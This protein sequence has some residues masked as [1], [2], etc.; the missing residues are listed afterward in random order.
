M[1]FKIKKKVNTLYDNPE[2]LFRDRRNRTVQGPLSHQ[3]DIL[4]RY[5][6]EAFE[7][8]NV[9]LELPTGSGKTLVGLLIA[10]FRRITKNERVLYLCPTRQL[11]LQVCEQSERKYGIIATPFIGPKKDYD[12]KDKISYQTG[13]TI[14]VAPYSSLFNTNPFFDKPQLIILDDAHAAENYIAS[15][16]SLKI[17]RFRFEKIYLGL[18]AIIKE[19]LPFSEYQRF[20]SDERDD[21]A[22][23]YIEKIPTIKLVSV[24]HEIDAFLDE[25]T[26]R[27]D[28][29]FSWSFLKGHL[30]ACHLYMSYDQI[31]IRPYIP[32][33]L[34]HEPFAYATQR[35]FMSA[36]LGNGGD[37]ERI[38]GVPSLH[39][40]PIPTGWDKQG[41]GRRY[42]VFP[43]IS[44]S[45]DEIEPLTKDIV[46][47]AGRALILVPNDRRVEK[48]KKLFEDITIYTA[49]DIE[50]SKD[51]FISSKESAVAVLAN[52]YDGIDLLDEDCR[53]L[54]IEGLPKA[55]NLQELYLMSRMVA[56]NLFKDRIRTRMIQAFGRCTRSATDYATVVIIGED[57]YD[58]LVLEENRSLFHPE[59][60]GELIFGADQAEEM[61]HEGFLENINIFLEHSND[62]D[63]IDAD[64]RENR[65]KASQSPLPGEARLLEAAQLE[66]KYIYK[67]WQDNYEECVDLSQKISDILVGD[68][69][70]GLRGLWYYF[71]ASASEL[72][73]QQLGDRAFI[74]KASDLYKRTSACLPAISWLR[75]LA[76]GAKS[77]D[78]E[79][80]LKDDILLE[81]NIERI[82]ALFEQRSF[83][84]PRKFE[85]TAKGIIKGLE[86]DDSDEFEEAHRLLGEMLGFESINPNGNATPDPLW[87]SNSTLCIVA[88]DKSDSKPNNAISIKHTRQVA[89]HASWVKDKIDQLNPRAEIYTVL[90]TTQ[91][92][93]HQD[94]PTYAADVYYWHIDDFR[95]WAFMAI[96]VLREIR[97]TFVGPGQEAWRTTA[98]EKLL[99]NGLDPE[100][101]VKKVTQTLLR[102]VEVE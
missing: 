91:E 41:I 47:Q 32:P 25:N 2:A 99:K 65:D 67:L 19:F 76:A 52:R 102:E 90:I 44:L 31:L 38:T 50:D 57:F 95:E 43:E 45:K 12:P 29:F 80:T 37:L 100:S 87:I 5:Q 82:E 86:S 3:S 64:I 94:V 96:N 92:K 72:A 40:L 93:I 27:T 46:K 85:Q 26:D 55:G 36:T 73:H 8:P 74:D 49:S 56:G 79:K 4:R 18:I 78:E 7:K 42:F 58:W 77:I 54:I 13:Q 68:D 101:L 21:F 11:A 28:L 60:Q 39:R 89:S 33:S 98:K 62:W 48:Y 20:I 30:K 16:W 75:V 24:L 66:V 69:L 34:T 83:A 6:E 61:T 1:A 23:K 84:L 59:L 14:A 63:D 17:S 15:N 9:A 22:I 35:V 53:L 71:A 81:V 88:E 70:K 10:E 51:H 97:T